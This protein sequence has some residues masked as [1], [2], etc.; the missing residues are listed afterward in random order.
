M[1]MPVFFGMPVVNRARALAHWVTDCEITRVNIFIATRVLNYTYTGV[2]KRK[3]RFSWNSD[4]ISALKFHEIETRHVYDARLQQKEIIRRDR[5]W[6]SSFAEN[7]DLAFFCIFMYLLVRYSLN[8]C[9][10]FESNDFSRNVLRADRADVIAIITRK[11]RKGLLEKFELTTLRTS[12]LYD[13]AVK[14]FR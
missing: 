5:L 12:S 13:R 4:R 2:Q 10:S 3:R 8:K 6:W 9:I 14:N 1:F 11:D 7:N